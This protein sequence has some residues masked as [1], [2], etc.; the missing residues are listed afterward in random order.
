MNRHELW[1]SRSARPD[2]GGFAEARNELEPIVSVQYHT[3]GMRTRK[4]DNYLNC[5]EQHDG[6]NLA[7][8]SCSGSMVCAMAKKVQ[9]LHALVNNLFQMR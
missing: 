1:F 9:T 6:G 5:R 8:D 4:E 7:I 2:E 3:V